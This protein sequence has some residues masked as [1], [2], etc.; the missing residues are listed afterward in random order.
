VFD[1]VRLRDSGR[2]QNVHRRWKLNIV[3]ESQ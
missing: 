2:V 3:L 1:S